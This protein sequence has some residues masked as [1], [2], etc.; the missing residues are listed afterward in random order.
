VPVSA[1]GGASCCAARFAAAAAVDSITAAAT[2]GEIIADG[3]CML[4]ASHVER[5]SLTGH[6][7][8]LSST[9]LTTV[10]LPLPAEL[11]GCHQWVAYLQWQRTYLN[12]AKVRVCTNGN[13]CGSE[14][15]ALDIDLRVSAFSAAVRTDGGG[16]GGRSTIEFLIVQL[17]YAVAALELGDQHIHPCAGLTRRHVHLLTILVHRVLAQASRLGGGATDGATRGG[18]VVSARRVAARRAAARWVATSLAAQ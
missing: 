13:T 5:F 11:T 9:A 4:L 17:R 1:R 10:A 3:L 15:S 6:L 16:L 14:A 2:L 18:R 8:C 7:M 12:S